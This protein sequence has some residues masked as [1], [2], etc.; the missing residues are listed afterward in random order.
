MRRRA[1]VA[2]MR[3]LL[4]KKER[5]N[6][7]VNDKGGFRYEVVCV[8]I[9]SSAQLHRGGQS[10]DCLSRHVEE[11]KISS[12][13]STVTKSRNAD[14]ITF[15]ART[16]DD[17]RE[18]PAGDLRPPMANGGDWIFRIY[19]ISLLTCSPSGTPGTYLLQPSLM[20]LSAPFRFYGLMSPTGS[21]AGGT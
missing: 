4:G 19:R 3:L 20:I 17:P 21:T 18:L 6:Q 16:I 13:I 12:M 2:S 7:D 8:P 14:D 10:G 5:C 1:V 15:V 9:G 11:R